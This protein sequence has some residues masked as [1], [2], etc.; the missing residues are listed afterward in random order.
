MHI[1]VTKERGELYNRVLAVRTLHKSFAAWKAR[2]AGLEHVESEQSVPASLHSLTTDRGAVLV[3]N[4]EQAEL[5][6]QF[7]RWRARLGDQNQLNILAMLHRESLEKKTVS[8]AFA[9]WRAATGT[10]IENQAA[11][12]KARAFFIQRQALRAW[13]IKARLKQQASWV[14]R[15]RQDETRTWF[16]GTSLSTAK[17]H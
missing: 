11:A 4:L 9:T 10:V 8:R 3:K 17:H 15:K 13:M 12:V 7:S 1:W 2:L 14:E 5:H 6:R 16:D